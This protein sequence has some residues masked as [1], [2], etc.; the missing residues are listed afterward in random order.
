LKDN[1]E[2]PDMGFPNLEGFIMTEIHKSD[3]GTCVFEL[4]GRLDAIT[5]PQIEGDLLPTIIEHKNVTLDFAKVVYISS[6]GLRILLTAHKQ[7]LASGGRLVLKN[8]SP[9]VRE[10]FEMTGFTDVLNIQ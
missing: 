2:I 9:D 3:N 4:T 5:A 10:V 8:I 1:R 6:A 7:A